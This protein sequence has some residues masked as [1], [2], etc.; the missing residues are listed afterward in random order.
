VL[1]A[2]PSCPSEVF[3]RHFIKQRGRDTGRNLSWR[4]RSSRISKLSRRLWNRAS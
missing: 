1:K 3:A 2:A 4:W